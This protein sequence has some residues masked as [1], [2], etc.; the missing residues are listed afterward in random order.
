MSE[1]KIAEESGIKITDETTDEIVGEKQLNQT[2]S[3][4]FEAT[5]VNIDNIMKEFKSTLLK[6][7]KLRSEIAMMERSLKKHDDRRNRRKLSNV[8]KDGN[9]RPNGFNIENNLIT[10]ELADFI[11]C[12]RGKPV[13]RTEV[14]R[15]LTAYV[16]ENK[17]QDKDDGRCVNLDSDAG[18]KLKSLLSEIVDKDGKPTRLTIITI[19]KFVNK[20]Y[21][22]KVPVTEDKLPVTESKEIEKVDDDKTIDTEISEEKLAA[23]KKTVIKKKLKIKRSDVAA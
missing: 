17:L 19:N 18:K 12:E 6:L 7:R 5:F 21:I 13:S 14:T 23:N 15:R 3:E 20:H 10:D 16:K 4:V 22:G 2:T 9:K 11:G 8:D 1:I